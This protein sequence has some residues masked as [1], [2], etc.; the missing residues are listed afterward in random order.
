MWFTKHSVLLA[1]IVLPYYVVYKTFCSTCQHR[2]T[3]LC[4][5]QNILFYLPTSC[6]PI[7]WFTKHSVLLANIVLTYYVVYK[8]FCSTC[9]HGVNLLCGLQNIL[10]Y[11]PTSYYSIMWFTKHSV[12][13]ANIVLPY[14]VVY[15]TFCSTC[16]H[17]I[18]L[19]CGLQNILFYLPTSCYPIMWFTKHSV[20]LANIVL[21][22]YVVYVMKNSIISSPFQ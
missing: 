18:T 22:Y 3:L 4:G 17:R 5:L 15:K 9:Q 7:M 6:Y 11:L 10:F 19:L 1:N 13:L 16:Q 2:V 12:P 20:L 21:P 14:Y 8:T